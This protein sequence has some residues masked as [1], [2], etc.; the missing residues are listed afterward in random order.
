MMTPGLFQPQQQ[1]Q[2]VKLL[3][4]ARMLPDGG[5]GSVT[6]SPTR[7]GLRGSIILGP[8]RQVLTPDFRRQSSYVVDESGR[9]VV[10]RPNSVVGGSTVAGESVQ[11]VY[12]GM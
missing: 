2:Q 11:M 3:E 12:L 1:Q 6:Y 4:S 8:G 7:A 10:L 5:N 9:L